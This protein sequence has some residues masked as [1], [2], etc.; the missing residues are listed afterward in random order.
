MANCINCGAELNDNSRFC[1]ECGTP[2]EKKDPPAPA[3]KPEEMIFVEGSV[4]IGS[5]PS[6]ADLEAPS[7][8]ESSEPP[9]N[10]AA[11]EDNTS[12]PIGGTADAPAED[13]PEEASAEIISSERSAA[14][15]DK[16][17]AEEDIASSESAPV[18]SAVSEDIPKNSKKRYVIIYIVTAAVLIAAGFALMSLSGQDGSDDPG[19]DV[20]PTI[21]EHKTTTEAGNETEVTETGTEAETF[22]NEETEIPETETEINIS[23]EETAETEETEE[24]WPN[25]EIS[26]TEPAV[27][28][29]AED[30]AA[31]IVIEPDHKPAADGEISAEISLA[32]S[33]ISSDI[34]TGSELIIAEFT[35][36]AE[37]LN[38]AP[39]I[40]LIEIN[41][42]RIEV[43]PSDTSDNMAVFEY[44]NMTAA[45][46]ERGFTAEDIDNIAFAASNTAADVYSVTVMAG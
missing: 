43:S 35:L 34:L 22:P 32:D 26:E 20:L 33:G 30:L 13:I 10:N 19:S 39:V 2:V 18:T 11:P 5:K 44:A 27:P 8:N 37:E 24:T 36:E 14:A 1:P 45:A 38:G 25:E 3:D 31:G 9:E 42:D 41:G 4:K 16:P 15:A 6:P 23:A 17:N 29:T 28:K 40:M 46:A 12:E 21:V 7:D